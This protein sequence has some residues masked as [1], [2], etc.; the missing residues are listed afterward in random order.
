MTELACEDLL[1]ATS[2][3]LTALELTTLEL[4]TAELTATELT[5]ADEA[6]PT[7]P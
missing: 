4:A 6:L 1:L 7:M 5:A 2:D 3:E